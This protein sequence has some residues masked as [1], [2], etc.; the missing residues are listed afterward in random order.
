MRNISR[1][2]AEALDAV[3]ALDPSIWFDTGK[4]FTCTEANVI[5]EFLTEFGEVSAAASLIDGHE[6]DCDDPDLHARAS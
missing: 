2:Q 3:V 4:H 6:M 1:N 5:A